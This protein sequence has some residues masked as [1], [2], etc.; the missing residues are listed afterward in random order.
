MDVQRECA[1]LK[2]LNHPNV[3]KLYEIIDDPKN[4][5]L[6]LG[7][8]MYHFL[9]LQVMEY[10]QNGPI[11]K[12]KDGKMKSDIFPEE[13]MRKYIRDIIQGLDYCKIFLYN[14][15]NSTFTK[16]YTPRYKT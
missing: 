12:I 10:I 3:V 16:N 13:K 6:F 2:K 8:N 14:L 7:T 1:I 4:N 11:C 5:T 15:Q 9:I